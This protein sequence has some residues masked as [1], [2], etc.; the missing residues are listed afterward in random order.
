[1]DRAELAM[2]SKTTPGFKHQRLTVVTHPATAIPAVKYD[3]L[4]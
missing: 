1:M 2:S 3:N 4:N